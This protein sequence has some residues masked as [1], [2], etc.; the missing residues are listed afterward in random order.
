MHLVESPPPLG[1]VSR[2][3]PPELEAIVDRTMAKEPEE[4]P[5]AAEVAAALR[6]LRLP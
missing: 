5:T 3:V 4:R 2:G 6:A 1:S